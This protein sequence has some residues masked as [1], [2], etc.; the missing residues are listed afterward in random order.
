[1]PDT[2]QTLL[3]TPE[4]TLSLPPPSEQ[5]SIRVGSYVTQEVT[6]PPPFFHESS[7]KFGRMEEGK[8][9]VILP[10]STGNITLLPPG[11]A[12]EGSVWGATLHDDING[13]V[14]FDNDGY[15]SPD[16]SEFILKK[17][18]DSIWFYLAHGRIK[19]YRKSIADVALLR[20]QL[21]LHQAA[22]SMTTAA[23]SLTTELTPGTATSWTPAS[24]SN[25]A[26]WV[27]DNNENY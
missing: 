22:E 4:I 6:L 20:M 7:E 25:L 2:T 8:T 27:L 13:E 14:T 16:L 19:I 17:Q 11:N 24:L 9:M 21:E 18:D 1:M 15:G 5:V 3:D 23:P 26:Q 10:N 12:G